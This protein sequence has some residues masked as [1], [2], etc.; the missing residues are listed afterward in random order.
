VVIHDVT[1]ITG[2]R[3]SITMGIDAPTPEAFFSNVS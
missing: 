1:G 3:M 2:R